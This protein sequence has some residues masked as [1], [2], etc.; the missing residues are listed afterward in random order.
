MGKLRIAATECYYK[1]IHRQLKE[2]FIHGINNSDMS[3]EI[4]KELTKIEENGNMKSEQVLAWD[5][6]LRHKSHNESS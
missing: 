2:Q 3:R 1:E 5:K 6:E 4:I